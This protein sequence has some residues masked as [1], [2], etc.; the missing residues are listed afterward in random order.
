MLRKKDRSRRCG[1]RRHQIET[2]TLA[3]E[4]RVIFFPVRFFRKASQKKNICALR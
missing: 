4:D 3:I 1:R 2:S